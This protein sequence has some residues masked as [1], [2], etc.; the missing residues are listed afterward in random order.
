MRARFTKRGSI[1]IF[2][3]NL[4]VRHPKDLNKVKKFNSIHKVGQDDNK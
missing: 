4:L 2:T 1:M 3:Q